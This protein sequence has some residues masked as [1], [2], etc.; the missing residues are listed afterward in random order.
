MSAINPQLGT[1][2]SGIRISVA[3]STLLGGVFPNIQARN[4]HGDQTSVSHR[5]EA[6]VT[7]GM[8]LTH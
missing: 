6:K 5:R 1:G 8:L 7:Q 2:N 4:D 3:P